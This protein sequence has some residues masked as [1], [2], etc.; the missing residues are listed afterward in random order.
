[1]L[2]AKLILADGT[3]RARLLARYWNM[4]N[5]VVRTVVVALTAADT[6]LLVDTTLACIWIKLDSVVR[7]TDRAS[8]CYTT[9][10][11]VCDLVV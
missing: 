9:T 4:Y 1:V 11:E 2:H 6:V 8:T 7:T 3:H 10:A 5:S